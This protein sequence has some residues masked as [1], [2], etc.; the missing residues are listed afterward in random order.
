MFVRKKKNRSG[1]TSIIVAEKRQG[2]LKELKTIGI[3]SN[4]EEIEKL[5]Q[6]AKVWIGTYG[7][8][9]DMFKEYEK[10]LEEKQTVEYLLSNVENVL[11]NGVQLIVNRVSDQVG[12]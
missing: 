10:R 3:S 1:T 8:K 6:E 9:M 11:L 5:Y 2:E 4:N 7:G 12:F